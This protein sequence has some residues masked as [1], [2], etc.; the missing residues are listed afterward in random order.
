MHRDGNLAID[1]KKLYDKRKQDLADRMSMG[2]MNIDNVTDAILKERGVSKR[3]F[4][5]IKK[6]L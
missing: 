5:L 3:E 4:Q 1:V 2:V 6:F